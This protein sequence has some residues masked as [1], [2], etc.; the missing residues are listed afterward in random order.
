MFMPASGWIVAFVATVAIELPIVVYLL[1]GAEPNLTRAG[2]LVVF[3]NLATHPIV[4]FVISQLFLIGTVAYVVAAESWAVA[5][6]AVFY[7]IAIVDLSL[8]RAVLVAVA[9]NT[10]SFALG[11]L[12]GALAPDLLS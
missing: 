2:G 6:E 11:R 9:A 3:A 7:R 12:V 10:A 5:I 8:G 1:R 4:W